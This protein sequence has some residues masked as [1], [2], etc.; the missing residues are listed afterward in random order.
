MNINM[1]ERKPTDC[2]CISIEPT[3]DGGDLSGFQ[4]LC[5]P[6]LRT[7]EWRC[8]GA[9]ASHSSLVSAYGNLIEQHLQMTAA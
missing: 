8:N 9:A 6:R 3:H 2:N 4:P 1:L 5:L 7:A